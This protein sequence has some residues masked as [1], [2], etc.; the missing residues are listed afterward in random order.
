MF[1]KRKLYRNERTCNRVPNKKIFEEHNVL[2]N[3]KLCLLRS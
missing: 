2:I 1:V 3:F